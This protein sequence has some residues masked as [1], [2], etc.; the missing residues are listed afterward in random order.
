MH[1]VRDQGNH[2]RNGNGMVRN[3]NCHDHNA[4]PYQ[5][6]FLCGR[7][8]VSVRLCSWAYAGV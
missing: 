3:T 2:N 8:S 4:N 5:C 6:V 7:V 1:I